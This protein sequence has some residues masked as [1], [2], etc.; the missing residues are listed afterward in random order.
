MT[1]DRGTT[2]MSP[3]ASPD[4]TAYQVLASRRSA[5]PLTGRASDHGGGGGGAGSTGSSGGG[6][7]PGG[8]APG[9]GAGGGGAAG[10]ES[11]TD[12]A[13]A[14]PGSVRNGWVSSAPVCSS[15]GESR[16]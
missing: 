7:G 15:A 16:T 5:V 14:K 2:A 4:G 1:S 3:C 9:G 10:R 11:D 13:V 6:V 12:V 8:V